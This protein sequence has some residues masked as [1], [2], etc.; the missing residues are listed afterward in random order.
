MQKPV[1]GVFQKSV[2][3]RTTGPVPLQCF[4]PSSSNR[5]AVDQGAIPNCVSKN[6][7]LCWGIRGLVS[8]FS[9]AGHLLGVPLPCAE[10]ITAFV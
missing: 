10:L 1:A 5:F 4:N 7:E 8:A 2:I 9:F 6:R 3:E